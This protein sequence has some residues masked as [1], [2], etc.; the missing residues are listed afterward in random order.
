MLEYTFLYDH[1]HGAVLAIMTGMLVLF[2]VNVP[3]LMAFTVARFQATSVVHRPGYVADVDEADLSDDGRL[4]T[5]GRRRGRSLPVETDVEDAS[6][7]GRHDLCL[8]VVLRG[9]DYVVVDPGTCEH[10]PDDV[11]LGVERRAGVD[12]LEAHRVAGRGGE[13]VSLVLRR[14]SRCT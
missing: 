9:V 4:R 6:A 7:A 8:H 10:R 14:H 12:D 3:L 5:S 13:R 11:E 1:T 2:M